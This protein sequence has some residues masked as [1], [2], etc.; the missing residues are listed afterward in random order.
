M[1]IFCWHA[2][3]PMN[4][5]LPPHESNHNEWRKA[6]IWEIMHTW[7]IPTCIFVLDRLNML[8]FG[9]T[10]QGTVTNYDTQLV[11]PNYQ[12]LHTTCHGGPPV[13]RGTLARNK[14]RHWM[15]CDLFNCTSFALT[16]QYAADKLILRYLST[17]CW[18]NFVEHVSLSFPCLVGWV[19]MS[20]C[21]PWNN[22]WVLYI[23]ETVPRLSI[24]IVQK[25]EQRF[26]CQRFTSDGKR[27][28]RY[29]PITVSNQNK[30]AMVSQ[31]NI[32]A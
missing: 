31:K 30:W 9:N 23:H 28:G 4:W 6:T 16:P 7:P 29:G 32:V 8:C 13:L 20:E 10:N 14:P 1:S 19:Q 15:H 22:V 17:Q 12:R 21:N 5:M 11:H 25:V 27:Q 3:T 26:S 18:D 2:W 24:T